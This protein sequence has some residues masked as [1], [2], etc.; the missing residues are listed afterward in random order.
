MKPQGGCC[1]AEVFVSHD[2]LKR[3]P[4]CSCIEQFHSFVKMYHHALQCTSNQN[5]PDF[6]YSPAVY[7]SSTHCSIRSTRSAFFPLEFNPF[8]ASQLFKSATVNFPRLPASIVVLSSL[9]LIPSRLC[10][11]RVAFAFFFGPSS[12]SSR[13]LFTLCPR[14][15]AW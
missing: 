13:S 7:A 2:N 14:S 10:P 11:E 12:S 6:A 9:I 4:K 3:I 1:L 8:E 15:S 5:I